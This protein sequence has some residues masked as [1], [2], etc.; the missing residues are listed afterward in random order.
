MSR[1]L[2]GYAAIRTVGESAISL[3]TRTF[4][5]F[6]PESLRT[7]VLIPGVTTSRLSTISSAKDLGFLRLRNADLPF[8]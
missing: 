6:P 3:P 4:C 5:T 1:P 8:R 7:G 2:T